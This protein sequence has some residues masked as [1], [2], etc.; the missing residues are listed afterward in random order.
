MAAIDQDFDD[1]LAV[2]YVNLAEE[3][4]GTKVLSCTDDFFAEKENLIKVGR[5][6][7]IPDKYTVNGKWMDGWESR[8][9]RTPGH[10][11]CDIQLGLRGIIKAFDIDT[12]HFLGNHPPHASIDACDISGEPDENTI[13]TEVLPKSP[14]D[15]GSQH[16]LEVD[17][18]KA[19][20]HVRLHIYP[21]GGVAR[22]R[23]F[24]DVSVDWSKKDPAKS[25]DLLA[26]ENGGKA[27]V[28]N[29]MFFS[30][31]DN[32]N[33]PGRGVNMGDGWETKRR[34]EP[35]NDWLI[36]ALGCPGE[37]DQI[38][39]DTAYFKG[40]FPH[41][42]S[43]DVANLVPLTLDNVEDAEWRPLIKNQFLKA[44]HI[45][46]YD[47]EVIPQGLVTHVRLNIFPCGGVSRL[48]LIGKFNNDSMTILNSLSKSDAI[49]Q[50]HKC[51]ASTTWSKYLEAERPFTSLQ[52]CQNKSD[53]IWD[54][55]KTPDLLEAFD[56]HSK[57]GDLDSLKKKYHNTTAWS[58][59]EQANV[60]DSDLN[61]LKELQQLNH[62][63]EN[64]F[65]FIFIVFAT[66]KSAK[67]ML[68]ILKSRIQNTKDEELKN[69]SIEQNKITR[70]R[71]EKL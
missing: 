16:L 33:I 37:I 35:G 39:L 10:D 28:A 25:Y 56:G 19:Y 40:N 22:L 13:W 27:I 46:N 57:I 21:D 5:G 44:D 31:K 36:M 50:L 52:D 7:F 58:K 17:N 12:N 26:V 71:L 14:L 70:L 65:G 60:A 41:S 38:E 59:D 62:D 8:R 3:R 54:Q 51:C 49:S 6:I 24:G 64:K 69:A 2:K 43:I 48:R 18:D 23:V 1:R 42:F 11:Y 63:Y 53:A 9:K 47:S 45:H 34:R 66:G 32:I 30:S 67:E 29:D 61:V 4:L 55:V 20:T 68:D 15:P